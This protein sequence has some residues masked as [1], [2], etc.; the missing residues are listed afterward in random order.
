MPLHKIPHIDL[1]SLIKDN[2][3]TDEHDITAQ[4]IVELRPAKKRGYLT[5]SELEKICYWKSA[6]AIN[7]I[8]KNTPYK[9]RKIT[10]EAFATKDDILKMELLTSLHGVG[11]PMASAILMLLNPNRYGVIDIRVWLLLFSMGVVDSNPTGK[12]LKISEYYSLLQLL[13]HYS[14]TFKVSARDIERTLFYYH[15]DHNKGNLYTT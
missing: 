12:N 1:D 5:K 2:L 3:V 9:I 8:K 15:I 14:K 11:V 7:Y 4:Q 13:R 10:T 6:R